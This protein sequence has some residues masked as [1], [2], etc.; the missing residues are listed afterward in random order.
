MLIYCIY[1]KFS[2]YIQVT[3]LFHNFIKFL[4]GL[5][6]L[7]LDIFIFNGLEYNNYIIRQSLISPH[8]NL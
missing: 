5:Y 7:K 6:K 2:I 4:I 8:K 1:T 3:Y